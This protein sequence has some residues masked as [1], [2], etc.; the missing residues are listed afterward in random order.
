MG[1]F[2][3]IK[4]YVTGGAAE[5]KLV[6]ENQVVDGSDPVRLFIHARAKDDC[7]VKEVYFRMRG[8]ETYVKREETI[9]TDS[10]GDSSRTYR[11]VV[12]TDIHIGTKTTVARDISLVAG[13][14]EKWLVEFEIPANSCPTFH[15]KEVSFKWEVYAGLDMPGNDPDSGWVEFFLSKKMNYTLDLM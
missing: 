14:E 15:G 13:D 9:S 11:D 2:S 8:I 12:K 6:F 3:K 10:D 4:N 1:F 5:V 7:K